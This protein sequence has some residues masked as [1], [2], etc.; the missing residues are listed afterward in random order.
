MSAT[1]RQKGVKRLAAPNQQE[2]HYS[3]KQASGNA[4]AQRYRIFLIVR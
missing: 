1:S 3:E 2:V 4:S